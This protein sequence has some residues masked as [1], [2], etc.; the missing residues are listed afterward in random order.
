MSRAKH[1][2]ADNREVLLPYSDHMKGLLKSRKYNAGVR[3]SGHVISQTGFLTNHGGAIAPNVISL[4]EHAPSLPESLL[5]FSG[6]SADL[7]YR[8]YC[9]ENGYEAHPARMQMGLAS[10]FIKFLTDPGDVV[11]DP[12]AGSNTTGHAA[13]LLGRRWVSVEA[14][15]VYALGSKGRFDLPKHGGARAAIALRKRV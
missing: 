1:P 4:A 8:Q 7:K 15:E 10:F 13:E 11:L 14:R 12:F 3:P 9:D 6:T 5:K 2:K